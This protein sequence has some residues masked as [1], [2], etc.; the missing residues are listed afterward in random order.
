MKSTLRPLAP[1]RGRPRKFS[2]PSKAVTLTLPEPVIA[3]LSDIDADLSRAVVRVAQPEM[4][5]RPHPPAQLARFG[6]SAVIVVNPTRT[7]EDR[8]G[9]VLIPLSDGRALISFD[10][11]MTA[12][13][14]ELAIRD[15]LEE[16]KLTPEDVR[17]FDAIAEILKTA[18]H[19]R[20]ISVCLRN[21]IVLEAANG[22]PRRRRAPPRQAR[23]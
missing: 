21:I 18:R 14:L 15:L 4:A 17:I 13:R 8:T 7:L 2:A 6:R 9:V 10:E 3:A 20:G 5:R 23:G 11:S 12:A 19:S 22:R 1:R 16:A